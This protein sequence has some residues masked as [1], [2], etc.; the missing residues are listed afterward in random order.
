MKRKLLLIQP[1]PYDAKR[2]PV[3]KRKLYFVGLSLPLLAALTPEEGAALIFFESCLSP[4][5]VI[6]K[7]KRKLG[8]NAK[9][10]VF[11]E[12]GC[13]GVFGSAVEVNAFN[14]EI[15]ACPIPPYFEIL[16]SKL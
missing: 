5:A 4:E 3:K 11:P 10:A 13:H 7:A 16:R 14:A 6:E 2:E 1:S 9:V 15:F 12:G 8:L